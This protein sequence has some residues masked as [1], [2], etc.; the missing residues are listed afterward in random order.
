M[1]SIKDFIREASD[2]SVE[3]RAMIIDSLLRTL[4]KPDPDID[5]AWSE[6]ARRRLDEMRSGRIRP[7]PGDEVFSRIKNFPKG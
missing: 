3:D 6:D 1:H 7:V 4:N 5:R 2:L